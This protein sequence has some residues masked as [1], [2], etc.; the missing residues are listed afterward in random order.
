MPGKAT[1]VM[2]ERARAATYIHPTTIDDDHARRLA[3][4]CIRDQQT[5]ALQRD[6]RFWQAWCPLADKDRFIETIEASR[7][8]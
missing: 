7:E 1:P 3:R 2:T 5:F 6:G 4:M 8:D